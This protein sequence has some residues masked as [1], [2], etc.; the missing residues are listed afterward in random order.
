MK[1]THQGSSLSHRS[2]HNPSVHF[3]WPLSRVDHSTRICSSRSETNKA[4]QAFINKLIHDCPEHPVLEELRRR[5]RGQA[6][7]GHQSCKE[8]S[9]WL[10]LPYHAC[11]S[12]AKISSVIKAVQF[13]FRQS[14]LSHLIPCISWRNHSKHLWRLV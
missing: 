12:G 3:A 8:P 14:E 1:V 4:Q 11:C 2:G 7:P 9:S 10:V 13:Q 6:Q 5:S